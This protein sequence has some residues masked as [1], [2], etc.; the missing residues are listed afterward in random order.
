MLSALLARTFTRS[1]LVLGRVVITLLLSHALP[2]AA[3]AQERV[4]TFGLQ[5]KPVFPLSFFKPLT[6]FGQ[7][8]LQGTVELTG[9]YAFGA[10]VRAGISKSI[11]FE[12]GI[13]QIQRSYNWS[14]SNDTNATP[15]SGSVRWV[16]YELPLLA[17]VYIRLGERSW[18]NNAIGFSADIYPTD[19]VETNDN[20]RT[21]WYRSRWLQGGVVANIGFEYRTM[22][23]GYFYV[24]ATYHRP[25]GDMVTVEHT[26][27]FNGIDHS[28]RTGVLGSYL[29]LDLRYF[30]HEDP[31]KRGKKPRN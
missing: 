22:K 23:S 27:R 31:D 29:T 4:T 16:G 20:S 1:P 8:A 2:I 18:M 17:L 21:Y 13:N 30:F 6:T 5:V 14:V 7:G 15:G 19:V 9:G 28:I 10:V 25:F 11:S 26:W 24:G 12:T 3:Q